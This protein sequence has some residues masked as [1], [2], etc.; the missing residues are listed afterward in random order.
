MSR[1]ATTQSPELIESKEAAS[2]L[3]VSLQT[4]YAYVSR[5]K[6][7]RVIDERTGKSLFSGREIQDFQERRDRGRR[8]ENV[9]RASLHFGLP[10]LGSAVS[11]L[12]EGQLLYRGRNAVQLAES[13]T[14]ETTAAL[15]WETRS[16]P[17]F[18]PPRLESVVERSSSGFVE[19]FGRWLLATSLT[20]P[21]SEQR[22]PE[23]LLAHFHLILRAAVSIAAGAPRWSGDIHE[24]LAEALGFGE[25]NADLVRVALVLHADHELNTATFA[26]RC[27][28]STMAS[29]YSAVLAGL[30]ASAGTRHANF[31]ATLACI[32]ECA[33]HGDADTYVSGLHR[34]A[35]DVPGFGHVLYPKGDPRAFALLDM[36]RRRYP[37]RYAIVGRVIEAVRTIQGV[38]PKNDLA[39]AALAHVCDCD[40]TACR[41]I[42]L[43]ARTVGWLAHTAEQYASPLLIRPRAHAR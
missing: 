2:R 26:V 15:L 23:H 16:L 40:A 12:H 6:L 10:V 30:C 35:L 24:Q 38:H 20:Q 4:L 39:L 37:E 41:T 8:P 36:I 22:S 29:P 9:A 7:G 42:F 3:G 33:R 19:N 1:N 14:L 31:E 18:H 43:V 28:A 5:G 27:V 25:A 17:R 13:G 11:S 32:D 34:N 21:R